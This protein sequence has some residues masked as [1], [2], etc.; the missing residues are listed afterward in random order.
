MRGYTPIDSRPRT[1]YTLLSFAASRYLLRAQNLA[2]RCV[3]FCTVPCFQLHYTP[4][5]GPQPVGTTIDDVSFGT[6]FANPSGSHM[7]L[8][9]PAKAVPFRS[10]SDEGFVARPTTHPPCRK[11]GAIDTRRSHRRH[12][13]KSLSWLFLPFRCRVCGARF[14]KTRFALR[15]NDEVVGL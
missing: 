4:M 5:L 13:E 12:L 9:Q 3:Y 11:C 8:K 15:R 7:G 1:K 10:V 14:W 6:R 2:R